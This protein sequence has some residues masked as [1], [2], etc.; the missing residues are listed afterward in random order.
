MKIYL[1][2]E[3]PQGSATW[4][5]LRMGRPTAS[6]CADVVTEVKGELSKARF[7]YGYQLIAERVL[8]EPFTMDLGHLPWVVHGQERE[9]EAA[10]AYAAITGGECHKVGFVATDDERYG[11]SPDL[12]VTTGAQKGAAEIKSPKETTQ[13][14]YLLSGPG[15]H[16]RCQAQMQVLV[17]NLNWVDFFSHNERCPPFMQRFNPDDEF[18]K[19]I[20]G[21]LLTFCD[22]LDHWEAKVRAMGMFA[23]AAKMAS[24]ADRL[25]DMLISDIDRLRGLQEILDKEGDAAFI[26]ALGELPHEQKQRVRMAIEGT[27][28]ILRSESL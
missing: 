22:E 11:C 27:K 5:R 28:Q 21:H 17:C 18:I 25:A 20:E 9:G 6:R 1:E 23:P 10:K 3:A 13:I 16:Y 8:Q 7:K 14:E 4:H 19:K 24:D 26:A 12:L 2:S 15:S